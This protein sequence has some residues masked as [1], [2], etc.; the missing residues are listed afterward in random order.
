MG[1]LQ[2]NIKDFR[3]N[4]GVSLSEVAL[5]VGMSKAQVWQMETGKCNPSLSTLM[6]LATYYKTTVATL[7]GEDFNNTDNEKCAYMFRLL[8]QLEANDLIL[9]DNILQTL[10]K[11]RKGQ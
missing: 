2:K 11:T 1:V 3:L 10:I 8:Q 4:K 6:K 9:L 7:I 5:S